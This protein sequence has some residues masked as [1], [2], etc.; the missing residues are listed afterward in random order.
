MHRSY[1]EMMQYKRRSLVMAT[2]GYKNSFICL[3]YAIEYK[4]I[5]LGANMW[6]SNVIHSHHTQKFNIF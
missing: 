5:F 6:L 2:A 1:A 3:V 4:K